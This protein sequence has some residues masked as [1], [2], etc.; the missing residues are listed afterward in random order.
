[1][2]PDALVSIEPDGTL[3]V[4]GGSWWRCRPAGEP[5][6]LGERWPGD[7]AINPLRSGGVWI[8][9]TAPAFAPAILDFAS[10]PTGTLLL[11]L[12]EP[13]APLPT[14]VQLASVAASLL[15]TAAPTAGDL[16]LLLS[17]PWADPVALVELSAILAASLDREVHAAIGLPLLTASGYSS[18]HLAPDGTPGWEPYLT[19][20]TACPVR[21]S[22]TAVAW[23]GHPSWA[24]AGPA[25][26]HAFPGWELEAISAGLWLRPAIGTA[27]R[28]P[29]CADPTRRSRCWWSAR[30]G[31]R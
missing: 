30:P 18:V 31:S 2:A 6:A 29:G 7:A 20:L 24:P 11:V 8:T 12:G 10:A 21:R 1:M 19:E 26:Y 22:V 5:E 25:R 15:A 13:G 4:T 14:G 3:L 16:R 9:A 23:R 28:A 27:D 17:A